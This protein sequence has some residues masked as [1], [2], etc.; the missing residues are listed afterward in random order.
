MS[1]VEHVATWIGLILAVASIVLAG[2]SILFTWVVNKRA[3]ALND[4][5]IKALTKLET[6]MSRVSDDVR[7]LIRDAWTRLV[8]GPSLPGEGLEPWIEPQTPESASGKAVAKPTEPPA[9]RY[10]PYTATVDAVRRFSLEA[11][12]LLRVL[13]QKGGWTSSSTRRL[14]ALRSVGPCLN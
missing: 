12:C 8:V 14:G 9:V 5:T 6:D 10:D 1:E 4:Q 13:H 2:V 11:Q 3:E 7:G